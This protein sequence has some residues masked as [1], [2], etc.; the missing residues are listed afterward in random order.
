MHVPA[1]HPSTMLN[2]LT[3]DDITI[4][5]LER[6]PSIVKFNGAQLGTENFEF[7][8]ETKVDIIIDTSHFSHIYCA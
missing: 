6:A 8:E 1:S 5:G 7:N 2:N 3:M 4:Y